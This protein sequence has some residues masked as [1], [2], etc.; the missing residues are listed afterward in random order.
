MPSVDALEAVRAIG[1]EAVPEDVAFSVELVEEIPVKPMTKFP[2]YV[3]LDP[4]E[5]NALDGS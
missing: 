3:D 4:P 2:L 1:R 5:P